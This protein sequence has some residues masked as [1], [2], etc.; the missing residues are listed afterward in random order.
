MT[1]ISGSFLIGAE[2][3]AS[4]CFS[5]ATTF[6]FPRHP[7]D[8]MSA[9]GSK[10][11]SGGTP[12]LPPRAL[13]RPQAGICH[14]MS[15]PRR[16]SG[17]V[18]TRARVPAQ[19]TL[20]DGQA[21]ARDVRANTLALDAKRGRVCSLFAMSAGKG[22]PGQPTG[23]SKR[24]DLSGE[25][26]GGSKIVCAKEW[27]AE[28]ASGPLGKEGDLLLPPEVEFLLGAQ[29]MRWSPKKRRKRRSRRCRRFAGRRY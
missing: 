20:R 13:K 24:Q 14:R 27:P 17:A 28:K 15:Q 4:E 8:S 10:N 29:I 1:T 6:R 19:N 12:E 3:V 16:S 7:A 21:V 23:P 9:R 25:E 2:S 26:R 18:R 22:A 5:S 11:A